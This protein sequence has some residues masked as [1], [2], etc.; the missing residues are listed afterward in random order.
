MLP[1]RLESNLQERQVTFFASHKKVSWLLL[2]SL[3]FTVRSFR[4]HHTARSHSLTEPKVHSQPLYVLAR[5]ATGC[6]TDFCWHTP[7]LIAMPRK[8]PALCNLAVTR[9]YKLPQ[10]VALAGNPHSL[11]FLFGEPPQW[12]QYNIAITS[13]QHTA[14]GSFTFFSDFYF[15][16]PSVYFDRHISKSNRFCSCFYTIPWILFP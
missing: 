15:F 4:T 8:N 14:E 1:C 5:C 11:G 10:P 2:C 16:N 13:C 3:G 12:S 6:V 9:L 7:R